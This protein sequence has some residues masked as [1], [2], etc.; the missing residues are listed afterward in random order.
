MKSCV[1]INKECSECII[2]YL[3]IPYWFTQSHPSKGEKL[4]A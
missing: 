3:N 2:P 1:W 4:Q